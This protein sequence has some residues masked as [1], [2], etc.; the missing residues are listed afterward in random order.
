MVD[1][2]YVTLIRCIT[3]LYLVNR[4]PNGWD[5]VK[6]IVKETLTHIEVPTSTIDDD[7]YGRSVLSL[8]SMV[9]WMLAATGGV[10]FD[11]GDILSRVRLN[12]RD[13]EA[14]MQ[15]LELALS[16]E[17]DEERCKKRVRT[18]LSEL[19]FELDK[20]RIKK[21]IASANHKIN[22][23]IDTV[24]HKEAIRDLQVKLSTLSGGSEADGEKAGFAGRLNTDDVKAMSDVFAKAKEIHSVDG[25]LRTGLVG[26]N[27]AAGGYG[28][29]RG[30]LVNYGGLTGHYKTGILNDLVRQIPLYNKPWLIDKKKIPGVVRVSF[31]NK[32]EQDLP[33]IY[34]ALVEHETG[35]MI[36]IAEVD[37]VKAAMY[38]Q[39]RLGVNG[40]KFF[41]ESYDPN[42][43][44]VYDLLDLLNKYEADGIEIHFLV[45][46]YLE[47][48]AK[49]GGDRLDECINEAFQILRNHCFPKGI[50]VVTAHQLSS[51][52]ID[53][54]REG[55]TNLAERVSEGSYYRNTKSLNQKLDL[56]MILHI[57]KAKGR[58]F[59][60][61]A[62]GKH[63][64]GERTPQKHRVFAYEFH[65]VG[66][67]RDDINDD[68]PSVIYG[69]NDHI[70]KIGMGE[71]ND[72]D[73]SM[74]DW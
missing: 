32:L 12:M 62:R 39:R 33:S 48:I 49:S 52:A 36:D 11:K 27:R 6:R 17:L 74:D 19:K 56:E 26:Q 21:L 10:D 63:R 55:G 67:I 28:F 15:E 64:G 25:T 7:S 35:E 34:R 2:P 13:G 42:N 29:K 37:P 58:S 41:M 45:V 66:G 14:Y 59:L 44:D 9:E 4:L 70:A 68:V 50:T 72:S 71:G 61:F 3:A 40:Y 51:A 73:A 69:L 16:V 1:S 57:V 20:L 53:I 46:D 30:E 24:D 18:I 8:R 22:Y 43:F 31:E 5:D 38:V 23:S 47:L 54:Q 60:T 65:A